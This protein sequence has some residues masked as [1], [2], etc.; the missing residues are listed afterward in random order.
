MIGPRSMATNHAP[1]PSMPIHAHALPP[2]RG[3]RPAPGPLRSVPARARRR[4]NSA[5]TYRFQAEA[6]V[7]LPTAMAI[8]PVIFFTVACFFKTFLNFLIV[9]LFL[10]LIAAI[11]QICPNPQTKNP[12]RFF[13]F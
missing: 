9:N 13:L 1:H 5:S 11:D 7:A 3:H 2:H 8:H 6:P 10:Q 4:S 12:V